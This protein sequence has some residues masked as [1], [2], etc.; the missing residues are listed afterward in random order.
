MST[1]GYPLTITSC[2]RMM[3][4]AG[5]KIKIIKMVKKLFSSDKPKI[6]LYKKKR[7][8]SFHEVDSIL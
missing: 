5:K 2:M 6:V 4:F 8:V 3:I 7:I 1:T